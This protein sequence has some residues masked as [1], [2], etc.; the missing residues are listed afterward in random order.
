[1]SAKP[2]IAEMRARYE[3]QFGVAAGYLPADIDEVK[4]WLEQ[5]LASA[6][7]ARAVGELVDNPAVSALG[8][9]INTDFEIKNL[10][11]LM[12]EESGG[13]REHGSPITSVADL[14]DV[15][16][17]I[18][19]QAPA[20]TDVKSQQNFFPMSSIFVHM[21]YTPAGMFLFTL[22]RFNNAVRAVLQSWCDYLD[23]PVS[24]NVINKTD[25]WLSPP[26][27]RLMNLKDFV[28]PDPTAPNGEFTSFNDYFHR[29]INLETRQLAG[30]G[31]PKV[32]VSANDGTVYRIARNVQKSAEFMLKGQPYSLENMLNNINENGVTVDSFVG[33]DVFQAF[34]SGANYHRWR[35]PVS[36]KIVV[37]QPVA[38]LMFSELPW[39]GYDPSAGTLS[40]G[41]QASVNTRG[42]VFIKADHAPLR[43]VCVMPIGIT[44]ISS[45]NFTR[46]VNDHVD[47]GDELGYF[48][49]GGSTLCVIFQP[50]AVKEFRWP[51]P[52]YPL[53]PP[54]PISINVRDWIALA[55]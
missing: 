22:V 18:V 35:A 26:A 40:Q 6:K 21:M 34:L 28:I 2:T 14:V 19:A 49:Y 10:F 24:L 9:L 41:Y 4:R 38:G 39:P 43:T 13:Q 45:I 27:A 23:S 37:Q 16:N 44:E 50:G 31:D 17:L 25:G 52:K 33:G 7:A 42:L 8:E 1:M 12:L 20:F 11:K 29:E 55:N 15:M 30:A 53:C 54:C 46:S 47:K 48:S 5:Q 36:G 32:I 3:G 51:Y